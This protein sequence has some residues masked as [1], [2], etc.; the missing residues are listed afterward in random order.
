MLQHMNQDVKDWG[1]NLVGFMGP[2]VLL[3]CFCALVLT[4]S[5]LP[6]WKLSWV[7]N[8]FAVLRRHRSSDADYGRDVAKKNQFAIGEPDFNL[9]S[10]WLI[11]IPMLFGCFGF[12]PSSIKYADMTAQEEGK[13]PVLLRW[14]AT[15]YIFGWAS[16]MCLVWFLIPVSRHSILLVS[17]GW[18]PIHA[19][20]IHIWAGYLSFIY[21]IVHG[22][23][24][25][26]VWFTLYDYP[27]WKQIIPAKQCWNWHPDNNE[28]GSGPMDG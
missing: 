23:I 28:I 20:R 9:M 10:I 4:D 18:S 11:V 14:E 24:L 16:V 5:K 22:L 26:V 19:L 25:V 1:S 13:N 8:F 2:T 17:M 12:I 27:V 15:S 7:N 3:T 21:M 6:R